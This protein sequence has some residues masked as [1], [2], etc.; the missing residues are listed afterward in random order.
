MVYLNKQLSS[1]CREKSGE[2]ATSA[3]TI[4]T[5]KQ[6]NKQLYK[7]TTQLLRTFKFSIIPCL[8]VSPR[9]FD[10]IGCIDLVG[11]GFSKKKYVRLA[12]LFFKQDSAHLFGWTA[13]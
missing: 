10:N 2:G 1:V 6:T 4:S 12:R 13:K 7:A 3:A 8:K 5:S 9:N 11:Q